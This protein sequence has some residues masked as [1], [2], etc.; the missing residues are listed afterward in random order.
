MS[1]GFG[2]GDPKQARSRVH[3]GQKLIAAWIR[4]PEFSQPQGGA[5]PLAIEGPNGFDE[6][7]TRFGS[8]VPVKACLNHLLERGLVELKDEQVHLLRMSYV[9]EGLSPE[10]L[11][12]MAT[13]AAGLLGTLEHNMRTDTTPRFERKV[14]FRHLKPEGV[15]ILNQAAKTAGQA[16]LEQLDQALAPHACQDAE[17]DTVHAGLGV[18]VYIDS[19][20]NH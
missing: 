19:D 13:D 17:A 7:V 6:L 20:Q 15:A 8:N 11:M 18:F 1:A 9:P 10:K 16:W 12:V 4:E 3:Y 5:R 2:T 14:S